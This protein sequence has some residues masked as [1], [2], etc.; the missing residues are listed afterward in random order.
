MTNTDRIRLKKIAMYCEQISLAL[1][2]F[3]DTFEAFAGDCL[4]QNACCMCIVQICEMAN[5]LSAEALKALS[6]IPWQEIR[7]MRNE[8]AHNYGQIDLSVTWDT[9]HSDVPFL[10]REIEAAL[11]D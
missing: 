3:G 2:R 11:A 8:F 4:Y 5:G 9:L 1:A 6:R 7:G 10:K